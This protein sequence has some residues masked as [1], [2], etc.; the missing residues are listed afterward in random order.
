MAV[1]S[2]AFHLPFMNI[3]LVVQV[4]F[5]IMGIIAVGSS[6]LLSL[7]YIHGIIAARAEGASLRQVAGIRHQ[8]LD[9]LYMGFNSA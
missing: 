1:Y 3:V 2:S 8:P 9:G 4:T 5:N 6:R 7:T